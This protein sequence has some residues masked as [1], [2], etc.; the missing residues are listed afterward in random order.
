[1][2]HIAHVVLACLLL[3]LPPA[4]P[5]QSNELLIL[6]P[7]VAQ[8]ERDVF[9]LLRSGIEAVASRAGVQTVALSLPENPSRCAGDR[10][11][12]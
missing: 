10:R 4:L 9:T 1:L 6:Y 8:P 7:D 11:W 3:I 12:C 5:A 2:Q